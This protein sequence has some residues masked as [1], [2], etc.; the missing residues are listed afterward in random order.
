MKIVS[1][2]KT[3]NHK[4]EKYEK[5]TTNPFEFPQPIT[6]IWVEDVQ[7]VKNNGKEDV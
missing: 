5:L 4:I 7:N 1:F 3:L 2:F 6:L